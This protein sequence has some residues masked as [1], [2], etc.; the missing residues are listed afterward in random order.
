MGTHT[1]P[2]DYNYTRT[3]IQRNYAQC[4]ARIQIGNCDYLVT[5]NMNALPTFRVSIRSLVPF[6]IS[7]TGKHG[8]S[9]VVRDSSWWTTRLLITSTYNSHFI[10]FDCM[11]QLKIISD[12][13]HL[14]HWYLRLYP[15]FRK[16]LSSSLLFF[17]IHAL[18]LSNE[19]VVQK[20]NQ[21]CA[22]VKISPMRT[23]AIQNSNFISTEHKVSMFI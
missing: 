7:F 15:L 23:L 18:R 3:T 20:Y 11:T 1:T 21:Y 19:A 5:R 14:M 10:P 16:L 9:D 2:T 13:H 17:H 12:L 8:E 22:L 4:D 6:S